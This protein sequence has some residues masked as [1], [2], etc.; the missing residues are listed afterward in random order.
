[1]VRPKSSLGV[2]P[3]PSAEADWAPGHFNGRT[4]KS[5]EGA[6]AGGPSLERSRQATGC[7][8]LRSA[9]E[10]EGDGGS[11]RAHRGPCDGDGDGHRGGEGSRE[12]A[13]DREAWGRCGRVLFSF[14]EKCLI[15]EKQ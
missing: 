6:A 3:N 8:G 14:G 12:W 2:L 4:T 5:F 15:G 11:Q 1:M 9:A 7:R 10:A 13:E